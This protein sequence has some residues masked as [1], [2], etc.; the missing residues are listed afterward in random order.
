M[1][2]ETAATLLA[3]L[4]DATLVEGF[5]H[6]SVERHFFPRTDAPSQGELPHGMIGSQHHHES[7]K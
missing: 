5:F 6:A 4:R 7:V 1:P 2:G 3:N